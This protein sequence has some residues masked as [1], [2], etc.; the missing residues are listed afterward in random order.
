MEVRHQD[1]STMAIAAETII[2]FI[3][4]RDKEY[5]IAL[6]LVYPCKLVGVEVL[7][8]GSSDTATTSIREMLRGALCASATGVIIAHNHPYGSVKPSKADID[9][10]KKFRLAAEQ[11]GIQLAGSLIVNMEGDFYDMMAVPE[12]QV[13]PM[14]KIQALLKD[15]DRIRLVDQIAWACKVGI[16]L[17]IMALSLY[18]FGHLIYSVVSDVEQ[19]R[20]TPPLIWS[21]VTL[22]VI[23][24]VKALIWGSTIKSGRFPKVMPHDIEET[25]TFSRS[26]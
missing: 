20:Q 24:N 22:L 5:L 18:F 1:I 12:V 13:Q 14:H 9:T 7:A 11:Q 16:R 8:I 25:Q 17:F 2:P 26:D 6:Y 21:L 3:H 23:V 19:W 15:S 10:T 4:D